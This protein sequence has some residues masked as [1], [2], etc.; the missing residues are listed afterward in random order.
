MIETKTLLDHTILVNK[1]NDIIVFDLGANDGR[2]YEQIVNFFG[3]DSIEKYVGVEPNVELFSNN[4]LPLESEK[5]IMVNKAVYSETDLELYFTEV[6]NNE[7]GNLLGETNEYFKWGEENP[8]KY[9]VNTITISDLMDLVGV[10]HID[11]LK[12]DIEGSEYFLIDSLTPE[13]C[14]KIN[15]ISIEFHDF[16][17]P[18]LKNKTDEYVQKI[19]DLGYELRFSS[20]WSGRFGTNYM[21]CLFIRK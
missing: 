16:I 21:D 5:I 14:D 18:D 13:I 10:N 2:F 20:Q 19:I 8:N 1:T 11:Y 7:A 6:K 9:L 17:D 15:Q 3:I 12:V 4:L